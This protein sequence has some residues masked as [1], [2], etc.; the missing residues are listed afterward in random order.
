MDGSGEHAWGSLP[1]GWTWER[2]VVVDAGKGEFA[3]HSEIHNRFIRMH[4]NVKMDNSGTKDFNKLP[5][6]WTWERFVPVEV[7]DGKIALH[8][9]IHGRFI[10]LRA[11]NNLA[12]GSDKKQRNALPPGWTW[13]RFQVLDLGPAKTNC[14][15]VQTGWNELP[16]NRNIIYLDRHDVSCEAG[17]VLKGYK[18]ERNGD[19]VRYNYKCC[20]VPTGLNKEYTRHT[21]LNSLGSNQYNLVYLDRHEVK[22]PDG[23]IM[24]QFR[25]NP[26]SGKFRYT[27]K[28][29]EATLGLTDCEDLKTPSNDYGGNKFEYLDRHH[30]ECPGEKYLTQFKLVRP[31]GDTISLEYQCCGVK[32]P[33]KNAPEPIGALDQVKY[34]TLQG[35]RSTECKTVDWSDTMSKP[36][37]STC[38]K[39]YF[40]S[41]LDREGASAT[42]DVQ[43]LN[44]GQPGIHDL[45]GWVSLGPSDGGAGSF[46]SKFA[47]GKSS[48]TVEVSGYTHARSNYKPIT[49]GP[50]KSLSDM[51]RGSFLCNKDQCV[52][53]MSLSGLE[54]G[55]KYVLKTWHH[56]TS[57]PR[58]GAPFTLQYHGQE[59]GPSTKLKQSPNGQNPQPALSHEETVTANGDG[60]I[61]MKMTRLQEGAHNAHIDLN[62]LIIRKENKPKGLSKIKQAWCCKAKALAEEW[63]AC[64]EQELFE[65]YGWIQC[66]DLDSRATA[67]VAVH[68]EQSEALSA[69][70]KAKCCNMVDRKKATLF[71]KAEPVTID[72]EIDKVESILSIDA[73]KPKYADVFN[74]SK[75][76]LA[77]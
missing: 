69:M 56:S 75:T 36:G 12:D 65:S 57:F 13:E 3:F 47:L 54:P 71:M 76:I 41:G 29:K 25:I 63:G 15:D 10:R 27:Y 67:I 61:D 46:K 45:K 50:S 17:R 48:I 19:Q 38:P 8:S 43:K 55:A 74:A 35:S 53:S 6:G 23:Q 64:Y 32:H 31:S 37:W 21:S 52:I 34:L 18:L 26:R 7:G 70:N 58:G 4:Q 62:G 1:D 30:L 51:L 20:T 42:V 49:A 2:F 68:R 24:R 22:C 77:M 28:C 66:K 33:P 9:R 60:M 40:L 72:N 59:L 16:G 5:A 73:T 44:F 14:K 11:D 39:G